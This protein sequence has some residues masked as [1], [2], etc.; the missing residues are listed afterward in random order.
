MV[1]VIRHDC[2][3]FLF[4]QMESYSKFPTDGRCDACGQVSRH[5]GKTSF[6]INDRRQWVCHSCA[7]RISDAADAWLNV[8]MPTPEEYQELLELIGGN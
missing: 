6:I 5:A 3:T 2:R 8:Q 1:R 7:D 4:A